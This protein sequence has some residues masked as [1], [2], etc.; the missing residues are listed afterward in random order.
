MKISES[1]EAL[2]KEKKARQEAYYKRMALIR[3]GKMKPMPELKR[4]SYGPV[5][6]MSIKLSLP[7]F[8]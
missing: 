8:D 7:K 3:E 1:Y 2:K 5:R 4:S 6:D